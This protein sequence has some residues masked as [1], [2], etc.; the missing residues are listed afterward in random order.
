M[1]SVS[2][3]QG[4]TFMSDQNRIKTTGKKHRHKKSESSES[5][6]FANS[7]AFRSNR[8]S[9][10]CIEGMTQSSSTL[11]DGSVPAMQSNIVLQNTEIAPQSQT[12]IDNLRAQIATAQQQ[13][14]DAQTKYDYGLKSY[15]SRTGSSNPYLGKNVKLSDGTFGYVTSRGNFEQYNDVD[16]T[17]G[18]NSCPAVSSVTDVP[19]RY[20]DIS[21]HQDTLWVS[22]N[23]PSGTSCGAEGSN[24]YVNTMLDKSSSSYAGC[25]KNTGSMQI[26]PNIS[27]QAGCENAAINGGFKYYSLQTPSNTTSGKL[28]CGVSNNVSLLSGD[29]ATRL[30]ITPVWDTATYWQAVGKGNEGVYATV[31]TLGMLMIVNANR[32][33]VWNNP[34]PKTFM[35][36]YVGC[37]ADSGDRRLPVYTGRTNYTGCQSIASKKNMPYFGL[38]YREGSNS[39]D[40]E[41]WLGSDLN[42]ALSYGKAGNCGNLSTDK[43]VSG[44]AWSNAVYTTNLIEQSAAPTN[45][46]LI[47][48]DDGNLCLYKGSGPNNNQGIIWAA[49]TKGKQGQ[50][51]I[52]Y[53]ALNGKGG[54]NWISSGTILNQGEWIGSNDGSIYL[55][56]QSDGNLVLY[57]VTGITDNCSMI[58]G[59][60]IGNDNSSLGIYQM[61]AVGVT[62]N[63]GK[64][65]YVNDAG[66]LSE[67]PNS[68]ITGGSKFQE[69]VYIDTDGQ[70]N[71]LGGIANSTID[72]CKAA[73]L[74]NPNCYGIVMD[75]R[76]GMNNVCY[77][78]NKNVINGRK[79]NLPGVNL[80]LR[81]TSITGQ[82]SS[83]NVPIISVDT[84][85]WG[86]YQH[87]KQ[88]M[89]TSTPCGLA[90]FIT[91]SQILGLNQDLINKQANLQNLQRQLVATTV[92]MQQDSATSNAQSVNNNT[93]VNTINSNT[94]TIINDVSIP[95]AICNSTGGCQ[96]INGKIVALPLK[97]IE[98]F[99]NYFSTDPSLQATTVNFKN[100]N[101]ILQD[102][103]IMVLQENYSFIVW[104]ILAITAVIVLVKVAK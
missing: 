51:S 80:Y 76:I 32:Q 53:Q 74:N 38:Q 75:T 27:S 24:I 61:S 13:V 73:C 7:N 59:A 63:M 70:G 42:H 56:M 23:K 3:H 100:I 57:S 15:I 1:D 93:N 77:P 39:Q 78:K 104:S 96:N 49:G 82:N 87:S 81:E 47:L 34:Q 11:I 97:N 91:E 89:S 10:Q 44:G 18:K 48:Q 62:G 54:K 21:N 9:S 41:C 79:Q 37:Y 85:K 4:A 5:L 43:S 99:G 31:T 35:P 95:T 14:N 30:L 12:N 40:A 58:S 33:T 52:Q 67:Y 16:N 26:V 71:D 45:Y 36:T 20:S 50:P 83:C 86:N 101:G 29:K 88:Q 64:M 102:T 66:V 28:Q 72:S 69:T 60:N 90:S 46:Y 84:V 68:M 94:G 25:F 103:N 92:K 65:G 8:H 22:N 98:G 55:I 6:Y 2:L 17:A 19:F